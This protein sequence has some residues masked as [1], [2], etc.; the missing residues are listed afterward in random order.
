[1]NCPVCEVPLNMTERVGV[2]IDYCPKC[3]GI[4]LDRGELDKIIEQSIP[5]QPEYSQA[6]HERGE[7]GHGGRE[8]SGHNQGK[9]RRRGSFLG[10]LFDFG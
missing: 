8:G 2:E 9:G 4:W 1:M 10:D 6:E 5:Q 7:S 3:R